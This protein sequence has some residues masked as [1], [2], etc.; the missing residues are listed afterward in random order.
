MSTY[1]LAPALAALRTEVN[2]RYPQRDHASD[3]WIGDTSHQA[4][5]SDH[6]PDWSADGVVRAL[7]IDIA[8]DGDP[9]TDLATLLVQS[10][11]GDPRV[12]YVIHKF[13]DKPSTIW[14]RTHD[15]EPRAYTGSNPHDK[16]VH[17][18]IQGANGL[19]A[20]AAQRIEDDTS[21]WLD[22]VKRRV[23]PLPISLSEV[24]DEFLKALDLRDGS[25]TVSVHVKRLQR[26]LNVR[27]PDLKIRVD[28]KVGRKTLDLWG[29]HERHAGGTD[30]PRVPDRKSL[31]LLV[32]PRW[33]MV[34]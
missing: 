32:Q 29:Y 10:L 14:S 22:P 16:H 5:P 28:G 26:A 30:R 15:W 13:P 23:R 34:D 33:K 17:V 2:E 21:T 27:Y 12:W 11:I 19:S 25:V 6:N 8:P 1:Y 4:R 31:G 24:R 7:D 20:A 18:S 3:G 9:D